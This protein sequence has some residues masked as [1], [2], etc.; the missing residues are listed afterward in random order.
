MNTLAAIE[1]EW[2]VWYNIRKGQS[3]VPKATDAKLAWADVAFG[4]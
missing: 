2:V 3:Q 4:I 1:V